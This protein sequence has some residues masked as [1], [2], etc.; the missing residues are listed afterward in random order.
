MENPKLT[1]EQ[2]LALREQYDYI[3]KNVHETPGSYVIN[4]AD[5]KH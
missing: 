1:Q 3:V 4:Y 2:L 5:D